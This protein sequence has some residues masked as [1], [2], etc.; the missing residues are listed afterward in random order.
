MAVTTN[1]SPEYWNLVVMI[2]GPLKT[3]ILLLGTSTI[4][5]PPAKANKGENWAT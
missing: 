3:I 4:P 5:K 1:I 2:E